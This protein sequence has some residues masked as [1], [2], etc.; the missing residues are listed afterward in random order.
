VLHNEQPTPRAATSDSG[1]GFLTP[2][3]Q[4]RGKE[5]GYDFFSESR[6]EHTSGHYLLRLE[7]ESMN[8]NTVEIGPQYM[9]IGG[10]AFRVVPRGIACK[11]SASCRCPDCGALPGA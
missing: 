5:L 2:L 6:S 11:S 9:L 3:P 1:R 4:D 10:E 8:E 7:V